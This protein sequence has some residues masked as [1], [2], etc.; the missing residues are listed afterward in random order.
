MRVQ[1]P[2]EVV[3]HL[4]RLLPAVLHVIPQVSQEHE[5]APAIDEEVT[6][7]FRQSVPGD[8]LPENGVNGML[9][10]LGFDPSTLGFTG[11]LLHQGG[12]AVL[13][14]EELLKLPV[15]GLE[16]AYITVKLVENSLDCFVNLVVELVLGFFVTLAP[17]DAGPGQ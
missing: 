7:D 5:P 13:P 6:D 12:L 11:T 16:Q 10:L 17:A 9:C 4:D 1:A 2:D 3:D 15:Q 14:F 8:F